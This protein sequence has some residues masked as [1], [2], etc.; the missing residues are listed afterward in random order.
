MKDIKQSKG[1]VHLRPGLKIWK[2]DLCLLFGVNVFFNVLTFIL[3]CSK[4]ITY[5][6]TIFLSELQCCVHIEIQFNL[7]QAQTFR[8]LKKYEGSDVTISYAHL[9]I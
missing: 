6:V 4:L 2:F 8:T 9:W 3:Q 5:L 1:S 7:S